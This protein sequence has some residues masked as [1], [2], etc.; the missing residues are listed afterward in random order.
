M[1]ITELGNTIRER[2]KT[3]KITQ[4]FLAELADVNINTIIRIENGMINPSIEVVNR[5]A[6]VLGMELT[7]A[8]KDINK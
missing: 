5:I 2:R 7:L 4:K 8:V 1:L 6:E 3:L